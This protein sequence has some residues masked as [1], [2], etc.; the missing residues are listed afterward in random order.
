MNFRYRYVR[1]GTH[2]TRSEA[3][4]TEGRR[5]PNTLHENELALDVGGSCWGIAAARRED[6]ELAV[7]DHHFHRD[8]GQFPAAAAAVLYLAPK[9]AERFQKRDG[10][11]WLV[12]HEEPD[13]DAFCSM[14]LAR[15]VIE[16]AAHVS[17]DGTADPG[18]IPVHG[19]DHHGLWP[20][21]WRRKPEKG[22][23][24]RQGY[25]IDW[26]NPSLRGLPDCRRWPLLL[27]AVASCVDNG[28]RLACPKN[29]ALHSVLYAALK[30]GREYT[31]EESGALE[32]FHAV[33][34]AMNDSAQ[35]LNPLTDSVL[36][37]SPTFA[38]EMMLLDHE[39]SAYERDIQRARKAVVFLRES[40][41]P[42]GAWFPAVQA[43]PLVNADRSLNAAQLLSE[44]GGSQAD[45]V[46]LRDPECL[47]FKEWARV[48]HE[49]SSS[50]QGFLFTAIAYS[51]GRR[52]AAAN[53]TEYFF[54][55]DP[56]RAA[57][58]HLYNVWAALQYAEVGALRGSQGGDRTGFEDR[59]RNCKG[60][61]DDPWYDGQNYQATIVA[62]P[63]RGTALSPA[64]HE[65]DL[66]DDPVARI[67]RHTLEH[68]I[69]AGPVKIS[70]IAASPSVKSK[71]WE[72]MAVEQAPEAITTPDVDTYRFGR[73]LLADEIDTFKPAMVEQIG[74][75]LWRLLNPDGGEGGAR[76]VPEGHIVSTA[77]GVAVW[78]QRGMIVAPKKSAADQADRVEEKFRE[79]AKLASDLKVLLDSS[80]QRGQ[81]R[82]RTGRR[83]T[84]KTITMP[85][86]EGR[87]GARIGSRRAK[88]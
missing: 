3:P 9:I 81:R 58:R 2:F 44:H 79:L 54:S 5:D 10:D 65:P 86:R 69:F 25:E 6:V 55:I 41:E 38:P 72:R 73:T 85:L 56:E 18:R 77:D 17:G 60:Y 83:L 15:R 26:F 87:R 8:S 42:Y 50:H 33:L 31:A 46:Y 34:D 28:R 22:E 70:D 14:Y 78:G 27:A 36:E 29:R 24:S 16:D 75:V 59:A 43:Q 49:N 62:T 7:I 39:L 88:S 84:A 47:L 11:L 63:G 51:N 13:F 53:E 19:W 12:T 37:K 40:S 64:G 48:D 71:E 57:R 30:R 82:R 66:S 23:E 61:L 32:F 45:G 52:G 4:R 21:G 76:G 35:R 1:F 74:G 20:G 67:V 68:S 80:D